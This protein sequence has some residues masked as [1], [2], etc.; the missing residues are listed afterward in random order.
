[1]PPLRAPPP[2]L[3]FCLL[4]SHL[5][6]PHSPL[7]LTAAAFP[8]YSTESQGQEASPPWYRLSRTLSLGG[9]RSPALRVLPCWVPSQSLLPF[10]HQF[11]H[12]PFMH[13]LGPGL[14]ALNHTGC[15]SLSLSQEAGRQG[16]PPWGPDSLLSTCPPWGYLR[17]HH[18]VS[19]GGRLWSWV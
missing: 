14:L 13:N 7:S 10:E 4:S 17:C 9:T 3:S 12:F 6:F 8:P 18:W 16:G 1:M 15:L 5:A 11:P 19:R 2:S